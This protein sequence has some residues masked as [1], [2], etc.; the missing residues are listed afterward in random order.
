MDEQPSEKCLAIVD[1]ESRNEEQIPKSIFKKV[2]EQASKVKWSNVVV[3][4]TI[5]ILAVVGYVYNCTHDIKLHTVAFVA[6]IGLFSGLSMSVG[7]H[8]LWAHR[9]FKARLPLKI[10]LA[11]FQAMTMNGSAFSYARDHRTHHKY[12]DTDGDPK[13]P[14]RG[15][16]YSHIGWWMLKKTQKVKEHGNKLDF[17]DLKQDWVVWYQHR[18]YLPLF[19]LLG[20]VMPTLVPYYC[21]NEDL[22]TSFY[23]CGIIRTVVVLHHLFT[24]N[25]IAHFF[26][27]RPYDFRI[28][29]TENRLVIYLSLGEGLVHL[30]TNQLQIVLIIFS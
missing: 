4:L 26:G 21:W 2:Y 15:L 24:V 23:L 1:V 3:L 28:R 10:F 20:L 27:S 12:S 19:V 5:H 25:S 8:R 6:A 7:A 16:F 29:P 30:V 14:S 11:I 17:S 9:S 18:F 22:L 13:N